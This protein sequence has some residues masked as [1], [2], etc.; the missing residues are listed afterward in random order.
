[1]LVVR[2]EAEATAQGLF[3]D[4]RKEVKEG[5]REWR[6]EGRKGVREEERSNKE[7]CC[8]RGQPF[9]PSFLRICMLFAYVP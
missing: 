3:A 4:A 6:E 8:V 7:R 1:L 9:L 2:H 5:S